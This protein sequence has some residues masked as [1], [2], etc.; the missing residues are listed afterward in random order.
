MLLQTAGEVITLLAND[1]ITS[2][3]DTQ[4]PGTTC[5]SSVRLTVRSRKRSLLDHQCRFRISGYLA[6]FV[7]AAALF[8]GWTAP[9]WS[10]SGPEPV[11]HTLSFS[12]AVHH[13]VDV[14][15][16]FPVEGEDP[17]EIA[18][19]VWIPGF[20]KVLDFSQYV[21]T[22]E[23]ST[24]AGAPLVIEKIRKN[25]WR[26]ETKGE[27]RVIVTYRV[28]GRELLTLANSVNADYAALNG[29][30]TFMAPAGDLAGHRSRPHT[31]RL[32]LPEGWSRSISGLPL[33]KGDENH[34][35]AGSFDLLV[36]S[37]I[38]AGNPTVYEFEVAGKKHYLANEGEAGIWDGGA[39]DVEKI[40]EEVYRFWGQLPYD[41]YVFMN[42]LNE[43]RGGGGLEHFNSTLICSN[44]WASRVPEDYRVWL[45][46][47]CHEYFHTWNVKRLRPVELG[48]FDYER[49]VLTR[50]LWIAEGLTAYYDDLLLSRA[51]LITHEQYLESLGRHIE[52]LQTTPGRKIRDLEMASFDTWLTFAKIDQ[53]TYNSTIDYYSKGAVAGFLLDVKIRKATR[54]E[55]SLDDVMRRAY[56]LYSGEGGYTPEQFRDVASHVAGTDLTAWVHHATETTEEYSYEEALEYFG[57]RFKPA[58]GYGDPEESLSPTNAWLG[59]ETRDAGGRLL[60]SKIPRGTPAYEHGF[61]V[62]DEILAIDDFRVRAGD[63]RDRLKRYRPGADAT[64]LIARNGLLHRLEVVFVEEPSKR[65]G[66]ETAPEMSSQQ[67]KNLESWLS[68]AGK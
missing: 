59:L 43:H 47:I 28:Y 36:D 26:I 42:V 8:C 4:C 15:S 19:A 27:S 1:D 32:I 21:E 18:M 30:S 38:L 52:D 37:P 55:K 20:Y 61:N 45:M 63:W 68:G 60:I 3:D 40:V 22:I 24:S 51:G 6:S 49:E 16:I 2:D 11:R 5:H 56:E 17:L 10:Q 31:V 39:G 57:L 48:P 67:Q 64:I 25:S 66:I 41:K 34:F 23:A 7:I 46:L 35:I 50:S 58:P 12:D 33:Y 13:N 44:R 53:N 62:D 9:L 29:A 65:W 14:Q 54:G